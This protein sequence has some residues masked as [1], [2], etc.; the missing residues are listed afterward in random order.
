MFSI[1]IVQAKYI[2]PPERKICKIFLRA[3]EFFLKWENKNYPI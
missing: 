2:Y 1:S 3:I